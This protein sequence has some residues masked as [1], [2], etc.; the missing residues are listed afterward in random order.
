MPYDGGG[1][2]PV[3]MLLTVYYQ[4][5]VI[6]VIQY[7]PFQKVSATVLRLFAQK[8]I[9]I[10]MNVYINSKDSRK[11]AKVLNCHI[12]YCKLTPVGKYM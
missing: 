9:I 6:P 1:Y 2:I 12:K 10:K 3:S 5:H 8:I 7:Y 11:F 4:R